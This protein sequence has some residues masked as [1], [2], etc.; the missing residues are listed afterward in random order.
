MLHDQRI[1]L[2]VVDLVM[3]VRIGIQVDLVIVPVEQHM[4][5]LISFGLSLGVEMVVLNAK[6]I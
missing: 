3:S 4:H 5:G 6:T 2:V 1:M